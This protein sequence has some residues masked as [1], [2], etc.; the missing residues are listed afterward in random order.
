MKQVETRSFH[1]FNTFTQQIDEWFLHTAIP[2]YHLLTLCALTKANVALSRA[3]RE[4]KEQSERKFALEQSKRS[5]R[6]TTARGNS[7]AD[8]SGGGA[9]RKFKV[10]LLGEGMGCLYLYLSA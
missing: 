8:R 3:K 4:E 1:F 7:M 6:A 10:V 2:T 5:T 9:A